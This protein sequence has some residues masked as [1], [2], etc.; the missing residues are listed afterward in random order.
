MPPLR[1][2]EGLARG[3]RG[4]AVTLA[5]VN[6]RMLTAAVFT[7]AGLAA[8]AAAQEKPVPA[9]AKPVPAEQKKPVP[10][11]PQ[12]PLPAEQKRPAPPLAEIAERELERRK[13]VKA[14]S[15]VFT[16][17]DIRELLA[18]RPLAD[19]PAGA[20]PADP[21]ATPAP[22]DAAAAAAAKLAAEKDEAWWRERVARVREQIRRNEM[23]AEALQSRINAL[24]T[25]F[26]NRD[27]PF[28]RLKIADDRQKSLAELERVQGEIEAG[29]KQLADIEEEARRAGIP[30]GWIR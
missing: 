2:R 5:L 29:K 18:R 28:Q 15:T 30:P 8:P 17:K 16:D 22:A 23:F 7:L 20:V 6:R 9:Q 11:G 25:D 12:I 19:A 13:A 14:P 3:C 24:A 27:D 21:A 4:R 1:I 26:A 10:A